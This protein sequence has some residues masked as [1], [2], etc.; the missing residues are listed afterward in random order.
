MP[1]D[2]ALAPVSENNSLWILIAL[3]SEGQ[4]C[5]WA[6]N[7]KWAGQGITAIVTTA[8]HS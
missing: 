3:C 2:A 6:G 8:L 5:L 7:V 4:R 1:S